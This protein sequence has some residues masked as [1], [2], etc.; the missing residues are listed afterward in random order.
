MYGV[1]DR[2][3][4]I[5]QDLRFH[6]LEQFP[7]PHHLYVLTQV[8]KYYDLYTQF[9]PKGKK[10]EVC[11]DPTEFLE[12]RGRKVKCSETDINNALNCTM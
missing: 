1:M 5:C 12:I 10:K 7:K 6:K 3:P 4:E 2:Y 9:L 11:L 8:G